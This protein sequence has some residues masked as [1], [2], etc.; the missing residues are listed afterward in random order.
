[1]EGIIRPEISQ[2]TKLRFLYLGDSLIGGALPTELFGCPL[3]ELHLSNAKFD[4]PLPEDFINLSGSTVDILLNGNNFSGPIPQAFDDCTK[5]EE[6]NLSGNPLV[7][8]AVSTAIC[9]RRG[10]GVSKVEVLEVDCAVECGCCGF[11]D[12]C[13]GA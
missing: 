2:M 7:T 5:L 6:L 4:G 3:R 12:D 10:R 13:D 8:G 9:S 1:L 11:R